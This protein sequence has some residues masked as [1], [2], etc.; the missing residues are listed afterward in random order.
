MNQVD[1]NT[2]IDEI[3]NKADFD[4]KD[5]IIIQLYMKNRNDLNSL[6]DFKIICIEELKRLYPEITDI[7]INEYL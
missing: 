1:S 5:E 3:L 6:S 7:K 4:V 2:S